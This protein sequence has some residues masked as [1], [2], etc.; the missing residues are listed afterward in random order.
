MRNLVLVF[1]DQLN[2]DSA[3]FDGF[4]KSKDV[5]WL[6]EVAE[7]ATYVWCHKFRLVAFFSAMRHFRNELRD[8]GYEVNYHELQHE[9][10]K[11]EGSSFAEIIGNTIDQHSPE[12]VIAVE[13]GDYRVKT[14]IEEVAENSNLEIEWRTDR[15]FYCSQEEFS[16]WASNRKTLV[17]EDFYRMLRKKHDVLMDGDEPAGG[18]WNYDAD[19]REAFPKSG[20]PDIKKL[21]HFAPDEI[22]QNVIDLVEDRFRDHPGTLEDFDLPVTRK[23]AQKA[24]KDFIKNRLAAFGKHEDAMWTEET[25][26][27]HSRLSFMLN[28]HL[29]NPTECV[30]AAVKAYRNEDAPINSVEGFVRQILGWR[31]FVRGVYWLKMP[32]YIE[33][34]ALDC[35]DRDVPQFFWD[36][37][38][39]MTCIADAMQSVLRYSYAHHI[40]RLMV[41][42]L[43]SQLLGV[44]PRKF[45]DWHM[46]MYTDAIDWVSLPNTLGMSQYGDGGIVGTKPYC[47]SGN[48]IDKMSNYCKNCEY[49]YKQSTGESACPFTTLYYDFLDR[50]RDRFKENRR[51]NF[52]IKNLE[53]K[54]SD[55]MK[56]IR[57][58]AKQIKKKISDG[59]SI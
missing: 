40:Q 6:A 30:D 1:G 9:K 2:T 24:L 47:A 26:H 33:L 38:T 58:Q 43:F 53:R 50:H 8:S 48:Y 14:S 21:K 4:N 59:N 41:L 10:K 22:T 15:D 51:M 36:G 45:H 55:E 57:K 5:V 52:Q 29:L 28:V 39:K 27:A 54:S 16:E 25:F 42:G 18:D 32:E 31:E 7:E 11:D 3:A 46:A 44:H 23:D 49:D 12:K 56:E 17:L 34:N 37:E 20:P 19:N 13:P 35:D